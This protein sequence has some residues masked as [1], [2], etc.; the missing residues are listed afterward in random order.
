[1]TILGLRLPVFCL[2]FLGF[3]LIWLLWIGVYSF[4]PGP[5]PQESTIDVVIPDHSSISEIEHLLTEKKVVRDNRRFSMLVMLTGAAKK[6]RA[7]EYRFKGG[8]IPLEIIDRLR[9][10]RVLYRPVTIPE[11]TDTGKIADILASEGWINRTRFIELAH[12]AQFMHQLGVSADSL[13]GY[14]F[15]DTYYLS[16]GQQDEK[17]ILKMMVARHFEVYDQLE[18]GADYQDH[19]LS[20]HEIITLASIVEKE[21]GLEDERPLVAS[22]FLNRLKKGM[23]LQ[24]DPTLLYRRSDFSG[25]L[26]QSE[27]ANHTPYNT[28]I[29]KGLPPGPITNPGRAAIRA[30]IAPAHTDY[31]Y[32]V[33]KDDNTHHFSKTLEEHN[34]AVA[35]YRR[36]KPVQ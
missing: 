16:R 5:L 21:T 8:R 1:M 35:K 7:G 36:G 2:F 9:K 15:P 17:K 23:R 25:P 13:E 32:F 24:A 29:I 33:L 3:P 19:G 27:L 30:V 4:Q 20:H 18:A 28:Y 12:D 10:G 34:R 6:L 26:R 14:L 31:L 11:G 22:V